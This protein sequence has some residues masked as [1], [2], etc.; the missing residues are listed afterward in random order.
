MKRILM[1]LGIALIVC[2]QSICAKLGDEHLVNY[3][4]NLEDSINKCFEQEEYLLAIPFVEEHLNVASKVYGMYSVEYAVYLSNAAEIYNLVSDIDNAIRL[5]E[6]SLKIKKSVF[7][8]SHVEYAISLDNLGNYYSKIGCPQKAAELQMEALGIFKRL[9]GSGSENFK[10]CLCNI[11]SNCLDN[12]QHYLQ[13][14]YPEI[15][16]VFDVLFFS[17]PKKIIQTA[18]Y[19]ASVGL[20][21]EAKEIY[22]KCLG[23]IAHINGDNSSDYA[24]YLQYFSNQ[25]YNVGV[26]SEAIKLESKAS[27]IYKNLYGEKSNEYIETL[28]LLSGYNFFAGNFSE[29]I[30]CGEYAVDLIAKYYGE[31]NPNYPIALDNLSRF[32]STIGIYNKAIECGEKAQMLFNKNSIDYAISVSNLAGVY[33]GLGEVEKALELETISYILIRKLNVNGDYQNNYIISTLALST[34]LRENNQIEAAKRYGLEALN[35]AQKEYGNNHP[36]LADFLDN[37]AM[38]CFERYE[39]KQAIEYEKRAIEIIQKSLGKT[40]P[41]IAAYMSNLALITYYGEGIYSAIEY[42]LEFS[43]IYRK[44]LKSNMS[45]LTSYERKFYFDKRKWWNDILLMLVMRHQQLLLNGDAYNSVLSSKGLLLN[46]E[47]EF[48]KL[49]AESGDE[50]LNNLFGDLQKKRRFLIKLYEMPIA[51]RPVDVDSLEAEIVALERELMQKSKVYGD[52][53]H[54]MNIDWKQ[55]QSKLTDKDI[56]VEFVSFPADNDSIMYC[57]LTLK[58]GY[59]YPRMIE[60]FEATQLKE[61]DSIKYYTSRAL[62]K[63]VW[64]P[65]KEEL[66]GVTNVYFAPAGVLHNIAIESL[67]DFE[68]NAYNYLFNKWNFYRLSSTRELAKT[69]PVSNPVNVA[70]YGGIE[71]NVTGDFVFEKDTISPTNYYAQSRSL[72][73][74]I[75]LRGLSADYLPGTLNEVDLI[76]SLYAEQRVSSTLYKGLAGSETSLKRLSGQR[77][78]NLHIATHGFY[79]SESD[80]ASNKDL[81]MQRFIQYDA[82]PRYIEDK[83]M[84]RSGLLFAGAN[85]ALHGDT[86]PEGCDDGILTAQEIEMLDFRGCDLLVLSACQTGLGEIKGDGVFGLQRGFKKAGVQTIVMSLWK[87]DDDAT[88]MLMTTFYKNLLAGKTKRESFLIAEETVRNFVGEI[89]GEMRDFSNPKYWAGFIMLD[90]ID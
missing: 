68:E 73:D 33:H 56:A 84:T 26:Y 14:V 81:A 6:L 24:S 78:S 63:L 87:V 58:K 61:V 2:N 54:N 77:L 11:I 71:Y 18:S 38:C 85:A 15:I 29:S 21:Q 4:Q 66:D 34:Y 23:L 53:T 25:W 31:S 16:G 37:A 40:H 70:L 17:E 3:M 42:I 51:E 22:N 5:A 49:I 64:G 45:S 62:S 83:A 30:K 10:V 47:I 39:Y 65:L 32:Y 13:E 52:F 35:L 27:E 12:N 7:G 9:E 46:S 69:K 48:S 50:Q 88:Q 1:F 55:V 80:V 82:T 90:G 57:A 86:I 20:T 76:R 89:N 59:E 44:E 19:F 36:M 79:W 75:G 67:P 72:S 60:L 41:T 28:M 8:K 74:S 43:S